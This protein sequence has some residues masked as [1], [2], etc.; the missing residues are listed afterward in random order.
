MAS[1]LLDQLSTYPP[2]HTPGCQKASSKLIVERGAVV[3]MRDSTL[4][5]CSCGQAQHLAELRALIARER[6]PDPMPAGAT[7]CTTC[8]GE[9]G[10]WE[11]CPAR[12]CH[13][14]GYIDAKVAP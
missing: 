12:G 11:P 14:R 6:E 7:S 10:F 9:G 3:P 2:S 13:G 1:N 5:V 8:R 4:A